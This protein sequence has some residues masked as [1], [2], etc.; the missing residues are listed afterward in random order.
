M[1]T[2]RPNG[3]T[4][5]GTGALWRHRLPQLAGVAAPPPMPT[6]GSEDGT[7]VPHA[8]A[9]HQGD[10]TPTDAATAQPEEPQDGGQSAGGR[11][12]EPVPLPDHQHAHASRWGASRWDLHSSWPCRAVCS[13]RGHVGRPLLAAVP[14]GLPA[15][16]LAVILALDSAASAGNRS[17]KHSCYLGYQGTHAPTGNSA[18]P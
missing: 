1:Y 16:I 2:H 11:G 5:G 8:Q 9:E 15:A 18:V 14:L 4:P 12:S 6:C 10:T 7:A 13:M 17:V 3:G